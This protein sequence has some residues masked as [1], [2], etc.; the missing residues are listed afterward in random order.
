M[1][2]KIMTAVWAVDLPHS[3]KIVLLALADNAN[4]EGA[5]YPS[6][7]TLMQKC[8]MSD[9]SIQRSIVRLHELG[10]LTCHYRT[11]RST[12]YTV[13]PRQAVTPDRLSPPTQRRGTPDTV[14]PPPPTLCHPTPDTVSPLTVIEPSIEP[15]PNLKSARAARVERATRLPAD[16]ELTVERQS[17]AVK[18]ARDPE[19]E[20]ANFKDYW[21]AASGANARKHDW[22]AAWRNWCRRAHDMTV[23]VTKAPAPKRT[24]RP[25]E[26]DCEEAK[27]S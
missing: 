13:H 26:D 5:C 1:S 2:I 16:F 21:T 17:I 15:S 20:F 7:A 24:W 14:S 18:E 9:R 27:A 8:G 25:P 6:V 22:D 3:E 12:V 4:D 11:G 19:R 23:R 10:H